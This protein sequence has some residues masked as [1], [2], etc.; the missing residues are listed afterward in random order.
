MEFDP[1][2]IDALEKKVEAIYVSV[3]KTRRYFLVSS[4]VTIAAFVLPAVGLAFVIPSLLSTYAGL[5][6][7]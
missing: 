1:T 6:G 5:G 3:E 7:I 4:A 2:R